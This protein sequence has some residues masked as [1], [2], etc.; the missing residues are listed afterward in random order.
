MSEIK[1]TKTKKVWLGHKKGDKSF[2]VHYLGEITLGKHV[3]ISDP[4]YDRDV[5][6]RTELT[7]VK[8]GSYRVYTVH[9]DEEGRVHNLMLLNAEKYGPWQFFVQWCQDENVGVDSGQMGVFDDSIYPTEKEIGESFD[10]PKTFYGRCCQATL[11]DEMEGLIDG[12][13]AVTSSGYGDGTYWVFTNTGVTKNAILIDYLS[14][15]NGEPLFMVL[16]LSDPK[17]KKEKGGAS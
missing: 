16:S 2:T 1:K 8:P 13:G 6:C 14:E 11:A 12:A 10:D 7:K 4:C 17:I 5:W 3:H 15:A 9:N